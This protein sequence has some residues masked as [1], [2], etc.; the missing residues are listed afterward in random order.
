M[1]DSIG[2][3]DI[4]E[5]FGYLF[6][7]E[8]GFDWDSV[9]LGSDG[10]LHCVICGERRTRTFSEA[11]GPASRIFGGRH[12]RCA[13]RCGISERDAEEALVQQTLSRN[14][15]ER[16]RGES[17][18]DREHADASFQTLDRTVDPSIVRAAERMEGYA[19]AF[20][21]V[22]EKGYGIFLSGDFGTGKT[23]LMAC[24]ANRIIERWHCRVLF[25]TSARLI[26]RMR[27]DREAMLSDLRT[28]S[29]LLIDDIGTER[30]VGQNGVD[31][32]ARTQMADAIET[33]YASALPTVFSSNFTLGELVRDRGINVAT[34]DRIMQMSSLALAMH[35]SSYRS[36][37]RKIR[38]ADLPF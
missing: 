1:M 19:D 5:R 34:G 27:M 11:S 20:P 15:V 26:D 21:E 7:D 12:L 38:T 2:K 25:V 17:G 10:E 13:C 23:H 29:C 24:T 9:Y 31:L 4:R 6:A 33:R 37:M 18:I 28:V 35:G 3:Q 14:E 36:M 22:L 8:P 32:D 30:Y 16:L